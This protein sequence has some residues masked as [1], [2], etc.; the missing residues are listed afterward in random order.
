MITLRAD[1]IWPDVFGA[2]T[3][4]AEIVDN[5][6]EVLGRFTP[7]PERIKRLY[8]RTEQLP[9][10]AEIERRKAEGGPRYTTRQVFEHLLTLTDDPKE[11]AHLET[12]IK[13]MAEREGCPTQ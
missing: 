6:G 12:L 13:G 10:P 3:E 11:R 1:E 5:A 4:P 7:D 2:L 9:D 8:E